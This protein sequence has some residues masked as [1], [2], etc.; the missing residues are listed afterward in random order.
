MRIDDLE[1]FTKFSTAV[2]YPTIPFVFVFH[3]SCAAPIIPPGT[4]Q[5]SKKDRTDENGL[6]AELRNSCG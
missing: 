6:K 3:Y 5:M 2:T 4:R 1:P